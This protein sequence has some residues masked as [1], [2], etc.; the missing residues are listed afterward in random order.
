[1]TTIPVSAEHAYSVTVSNSWIGDLVAIFEGRTRV[2]VIVSEEFSPDL[3]LLKNVN[4]EL[5]IFTVPDGENGKNIAT[6]TK[7]WNWLGA[8]GFTR[9]DLVVGI[10]GGAIT[11][12]AGFAAASWLRGLD[13]VAVPTS[14]AGMVDAS[15]GGKTGINSDYGKNLIGAFHSPIAVIVDPSFLKTLSDRDFSAGMAEVIKCGFIADPTILTLA[16]T[17]CVETLRNSP[18]AIAELIQKAVMVKA[19]VVSADF[20]ESF[21]REVLNYGHTLG[22]A[23]EVYSKYR[24]RHGEAVSIGLVFAAELA[25]AR[26]LITTADL[27]LHRQILSAYD[28]PITFERQAWQKLFPLLALDKKARGRVIRFV[29]LSGIGSTV[30]LEELTSAELDAAYER[31]SS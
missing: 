12:L 8:S 15:V 2:A 17:Y 16:A 5:H 31:I 30:R 6:V 7:L 9:S 22:H 11:D 10:G 26:G 20:K 23:I 27:D 19:Q 4:S 29:V 14:L 28:L 18:D 25:A 13:W 1:M 24:L 21:A 3:S